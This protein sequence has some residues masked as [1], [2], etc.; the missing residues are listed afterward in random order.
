MVCLKYYSGSLKIHIHIIQIIMSSSGYTRK[1]KKVK[2]FKS[3][4]EALRS[5]KTL[6][7]FTRF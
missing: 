2:G 6:L 7:N 3:A 5:F 1:Y 4:K